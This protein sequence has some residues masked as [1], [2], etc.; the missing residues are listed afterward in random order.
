MTSQDASFKL[1]LLSSGT[2]F[3]SIFESLIISSINEIRRKPS[4][5]IMPQYFLMLSISVMSPSFIIS[6][7]PIIVVR[8]VFNSWDTL[9]E[10]SLLIISAFFCIV[11]SS[12]NISRPAT[13]DWFCCLTGLK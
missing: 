13:D 3:S 4:L 1:M 10:N 7:K 6:A 9:A 5:L 12:I 11:T 8:G 2:A